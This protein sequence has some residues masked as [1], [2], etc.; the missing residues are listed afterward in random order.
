MLQMKEDGD[1]YIVTQDVFDEVAREVRPKILYYAVTRDGVP[2]LWPVNLPTNDGRLDSWSE[3][4]HK[5]AEIAQQ[6]W[7][8]LVANR[9]FGAYDVLEATALADEPSWPSLSFEAVLQLAFK[10]CVI[11]SAEH[12]VIRRLRGEI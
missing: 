4:A 9:S 11:D 6:S 7:I 10:N 5:A 2:F 8:R 3:S 1:C 12:P